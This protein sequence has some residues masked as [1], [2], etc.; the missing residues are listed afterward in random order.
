MHTVHDRHLL[1]GDVLPQAADQ[2]GQSV[3]ICSH[4]PICPGTCPPACLVWNYEEVLQVLHKHPGVVVA[5]IAGHTH[6][7]GYLVDDSGIHHMVLPG[8]VEAPPG[9]DCYGVVEVFEN[10]LELTGVDICMSCVCKLPAAAAAR[11]QRAA[12]VQ[13]EQAAAAAEGGEVAGG[14]SGGESDIVVEVGDAA[15]AAEKL[16]ERVSSI[17][18]GAVAGVSQ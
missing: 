2:Q 1:C 17:S 8:V 5:S 11:Q 9:R 6:Q 3:V 7:N 14:S 18:L 15:A 10:R 4:L 16:A 12:A 13:R